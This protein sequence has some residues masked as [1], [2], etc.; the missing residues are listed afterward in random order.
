MIGIFK[1]KV[2]EITYKDM[3]I[4][5]FRIERDYRMY[6]CI[7]YNKLTGEIE[8]N[9]DVLLNT[10]AVELGLGSG[11]YHYVLANI[12]RNDFSNI[13]DGHIMKLRY[14]PM[15]INCLAVEAQESPYHEVFNSFD[16]L[17]NLPV[18]TGTIHSMLAP[19]VLTLKYIAEKKRIVYIMTDGGA[20][21]IWMS[22]IVKRLRSRGLLH[23]TITY[24][25]AFGGDLECINVYTAMIA[26]KEILK[27]DAAVITMGPGIAGTDTKYG[28]SSIEKGY[29]VDAVN[30]FNGK[31]IAVPRI[32]FADSRSRH[33]GLSHHSRMTLGKL[34]CTKAFIALPILEKSKEDIIRKQLEESNIASKHELFFL[35]SMNVEKLLEKEQNYLEKMGKGFWQDRE[36]FVTCGSAALLATS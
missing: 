31:A 2:K 24:G 25:N 6:D 11:G 20:L 22:D 15:Q 3:Y 8:L 34:C 7:N 12:S 26:A 29:I 35:N 13:G 23:G 21:P 18:I 28:F 1:A 30:N 27:A 33:F 32:S 10:T 16:S 14:T 4:S 9:D 36:Y 17:E 5:K 19:I